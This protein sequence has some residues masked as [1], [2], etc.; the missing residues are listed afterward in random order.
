MKKFRTSQ[1]RLRVPFA[2]I[3]ESMTQ[4]QFAKECNINEIMAKYR[5]TGMITH[6]NKH[7]GNFGDFSNVGEYK[8]ALEKVMRAQE[9]FD[10]I[11]AE[12]R[13]KFGNDPAELIEFL[14]DPK[15]NE[16]AYKFGLKIRPQKPEPTFQDQMETALENH[17]KKSKTKKD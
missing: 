10:S 11:P 16:D 14:S 9:S 1:D 7:Q 6:I 4:Q 3:G 8:D 13:S 2:T 15:N 5:K 12:L 17:D